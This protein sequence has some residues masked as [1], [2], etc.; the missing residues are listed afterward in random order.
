MNRMDNP[1]PVNRSLIRRQHAEE[2]LIVMLA[3][4][5]ISVSITRLFLHLTGYPRL[6]G[7]ELHLAHV[8][9][10]GLL[11][12]AASLLP[13]IL[14]NGWILTL[15][16]MLSGVGVGLFIDEVGKFI[17]QA[18]DYF[19]PSAAPIIYAFFLL[20]VLLYIG[21]RQ[22]R[23]SDFRANMYYI[24]EDLQE[25]LDH[26]L[27]ESE[28]S[29]I[30]ARLEQVKRD[31]NQSDLIEL[32]DNVETYIKS[33]TRT[34]VPGQITF[35]QRMARRYETFEKKW[36]TRV[37]LR[38]VLV[39]SLAAVAAWSI[40]YPIHV[41]ISAFTPAQFEL[42]IQNLINDRLLRNASGLNWFEAR[43]ALEMAVGIILLLAA[44]LITIRQERVGTLV[45]YLGL[46][47]S[48]AVV[49]ILT[50]YFDQFSSIVD[51]MVQFVVLIL[52]MRYRVLY[53]ITPPDAI[54]SNSI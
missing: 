13:L 9:W 40:I 35:V 14:I 45:A 2:Y 42:L 7:G 3:S 52:V 25:V 41:L 30:L 20:T 48:L 47:L 1:P 26:D 50:F 31:S 28:R 23:R 19:Y 16:A 5:A 36:I 6:G 15:S 54:Q 34:I 4:F 29:R 27:S 18:N 37:R 38:A 51:A 12:F 49:N 46:L 39:G 11:L 53:L 24:L 44:I 17:T 22:R 33:Q 21:V 8:L 10:G 32:A 43:V